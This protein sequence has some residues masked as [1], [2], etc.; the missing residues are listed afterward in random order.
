MD[1]ILYGAFKT[2]VKDGDGNESSTELCTM[3]RLIVSSLSE[4]GIALKSHGS[5]ESNK[6]M[7]LRSPIRPWNYIVSN[8]SKTLK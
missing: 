2:K 7:E 8:E 4:Q 3:A 1:E 5:R 6:A